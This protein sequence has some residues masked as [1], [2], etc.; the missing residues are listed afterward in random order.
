MSRLLTVVINLVLACLLVAV[1][2]VPA[3]ENASKLGTVGLQVVPTAT[4]E[5]AVLQV[6]DGTPAA[7]AGF[8]PGDLIVQIDSFPLLGSDFAKVVS[9]HL[10][11]AE[12]STVTIHYL[13]PGEAGRKTVTLRR[14]TADPQL[15]VS[16][17]VRNNAPPQGGKP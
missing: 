1:P 5:L 13:R 10:W 3:A 2:G 16:P 7:R 15:T 8:K 11:G 14:A 9:Q 12:G 4:G 6:P 17:A